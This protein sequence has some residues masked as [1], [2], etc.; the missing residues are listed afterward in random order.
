MK[1]EQGGI[2]LYGIGIATMVVRN[3]FCR[4]HVITDVAQ[5]RTA[6]FEIARAALLAA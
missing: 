1:L 5:L 4:H 2:E 6:L 3:L